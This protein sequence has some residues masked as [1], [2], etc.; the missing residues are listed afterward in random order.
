MYQERYFP[1]ST[2]KVVTGSVGL[3]TGKVTMT[4]PVLPAVDVV[5]AAA[6]HPADP[7]LRR[8]HVRR[9]RCPTS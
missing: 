8:R 9:H 2:F 6:D 1:G 3:Q 5:P 7:Q 4:E